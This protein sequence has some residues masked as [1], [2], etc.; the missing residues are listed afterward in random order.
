MRRCVYLVCKC[1]TI[2]YQR[3]EH[4]WLLVSLGVLEPSPPHILRDV[5]VLYL[6]PRISEIFFN[7][8]K[9]HHYITKNLD[10]AKYKN[11]SIKIKV[12]SKK[13]EKG[14]KVVKMCCVP[15]AQDECKL[16]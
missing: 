15:V 6:S 7:D 14:S 4:P 8:L 2:L 3:L 16:F 5:S 11:E 13:I 1:Y 9:S 12:E 10:H